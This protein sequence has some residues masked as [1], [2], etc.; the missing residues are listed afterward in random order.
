V[1]FW[2]E[3][4]DARPEDLK[5]RHD[6]ECTDGHL[7]D[8]CCE[9]GLLLRDWVPNV[10]LA[11]PVP[12]VRPV[13]KDHH[14]QFTIAGFCGECGG[15]Q[16]DHPL[17]GAPDPMTG[18]DVDHKSLKSALLIGDD[19]L[20]R[21]RCPRC[22]V[23]VEPAMAQGFATGPGYGRGRLPFTQRH[24]AELDRIRAAWIGGFYQ[25]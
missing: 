11:P 4:C 21:S 14:Y 10:N 16:D 3:H 2:Q 8:Q 15:V 17:I 25:S 9:C 13:T 7:Y 20:S 19:G 5:H 18:C 22:G 12:V 23:M 1:G 24:L 6:T